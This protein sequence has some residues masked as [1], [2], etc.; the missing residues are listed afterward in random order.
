[1][2]VRYQFRR[3]LASVWSLVN[4]VL[5]DGEAGYEKDTNKLKIGDGMTP[6]RSLPYTTA[7]PS[8][9]GTGDG[10]GGI[11]ISEILDV[12]LE[13]YP[14][15]AARPNKQGYYWAWMQ[16]PSSGIIS[17]HG[18]MMS[19]AS[20]TGVN[21]IT[22]AGQMNAIAAVVAVTM[23][24]STNAIVG[25]RSGSGNATIAQ[26]A[27]ATASGMITGV[28]QAAVSVTVIPTSVFLTTGVNAVIGTGA[29]ASTGLYSDNFNRANGPLGS[30]W[31]AVGNLT[32]PT[33]MLNRVSGGGW[34]GAAYNATF[35]DNQ[36]AEL[37]IAPSMTSGELNG[38]A[39][40]I[41]TSGGCGGYVAQYTDDGEG[42]SEIRI[43]KADAN[44]MVASIPG[45]TAWGAPGGDLTIRIEAVGTTITV[46]VGG[47]VRLTLTDTTFTLGRAGFFASSGDNWSGGNL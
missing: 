35:T 28:G 22:S 30:N 12:T 21:A 27:Q 26:I 13:P 39:V 33:I 42:W 10:L 16:L 3:D 23:P 19:V 32:L 15:W 38:P 11:Y 45:G 9:G 14:V 29:A 44:G 43:A 5:A 31:L 47:V 46:K 24:T 34:N 1:M 4:P 40:R 8:S 6:W 41:P 36:F 20:T 17:G 37:T 2:A 18:V 25:L 7:E